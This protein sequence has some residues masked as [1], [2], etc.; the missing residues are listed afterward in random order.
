MEKE[1]PSAGLFFDHGV[2]TETGKPLSRFGTGQSGIVFHALST[3]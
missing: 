3:L 1:K 2:G